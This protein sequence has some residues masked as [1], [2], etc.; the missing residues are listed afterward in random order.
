[1]AWASRS[2]II[3]CVYYCTRKMLKES[4]TVETISCSVT[5]SSLVAFQRRKSTG[6]LLATPMADAL[7]NIW[8]LHYTK[9]L[10]YFVVEHKVKKK[11]TNFQHVQVNNDKGWNN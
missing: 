1:M 7:S 4:E 5:F 8:I 6:P 2:S 3:V 9:D 10:L 11:H